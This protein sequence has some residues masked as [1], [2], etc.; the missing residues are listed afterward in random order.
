[1]TEEKKIQKCCVDV[2]RSF[3][4]T[5]LVLVLIRFE[6]VP[7]LQSWRITS[8]DA[9]IWIP[10]VFGLSPGAETSTPETRIESDRAI[11]KCICW[12]F[13]IVMPFT[14]TAELDSIV[15]A[16][17]KSRKLEFHLAIPIPDSHMHVQQEFSCM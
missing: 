16:C 15:S 8:V 2:L 9:V 6:P 7:I 13:W 1:M 17:N 4:G 14:F 5:K 10:S 12:L 11:T 3:I